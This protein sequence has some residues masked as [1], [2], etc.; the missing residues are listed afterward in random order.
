MFYAS[1]DLSGPLRV[2]MGCLTAAAAVDESGWALQYASDELRN[3]EEVVLTAIQGWD[4]VSCSYSFAMEYASEELKSN[5]E[6]MIKAIELTEGEAFAKASDTLKNDKEIVLIAVK[7]CSP[8]HQCDP[9]IV[10]AYASYQM[11][12][13]KEVVLAAVRQNGWALA[14]ASD[15]LKNDKEVVLA[16]AEN[17]RSA[18]D[19]APPTLLADKEFMIEVIKVAGEHAL[20]YASAEIRNDPDVIALSELFEFEYYHSDLD[21]EDSNDRPF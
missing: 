2:Y 10:L 17:I 4:G 9:T 15:E 12:A 13:D 8:P 14:Y 16:A 19:F 20:E 11:R 21:D 7:N 18:L 6:F 5:K 1:A 3:D